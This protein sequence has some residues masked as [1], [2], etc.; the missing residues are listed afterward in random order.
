MTHNN[1]CMLI[2]AKWLQI[3]LFFI[4]LSTLSFT[5]YAFFFFSL[6]LSQFTHTCLNVYVP[7]G[8]CWFVCLGKVLDKSST[9]SPISSTSYH[10]SPLLPQLCLWYFLNYL[11][12]PITNSPFAHFI[13]SQHHL[14]T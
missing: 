14:I 1:Y 12:Y 5:L 2:L 11:S 10:P 7:E 9:C 13:F 3:K 8:N 6:L 4:F